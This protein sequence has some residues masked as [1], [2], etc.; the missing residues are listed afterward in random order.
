MIELKK[1]IKKSLNMQKLFIL[2]SLLV[3]L[4]GCVESVALLGGSLS[5]ASSG[6]MVQSSLQS[7]VSYGIKK[8]TGKTPLGHAL[9]YA[10]VVNPEKDK[11]TCV[12]FIEK[13]RSEFCSV[14]KKKISSTSNSLK[15]KTNI[16]LKKDH[17]I[18]K[19]PVVL[20]EFIKSNNTVVKKNLIKDKKSPIE[21]AIAFQDKIINVT[22]K[23]NLYKNLFNR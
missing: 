4:N 11:E 13:T 19:D 15:E 10:E 9:A 7:S 8:T 12:S 22:K 1:L 20:E 6:K 16:I 3:F 21:L 17:K 18:N 23:N 2:L 14:I 5:G